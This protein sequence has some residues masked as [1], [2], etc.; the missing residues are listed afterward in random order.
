[1]TMPS[2]AV[3]HGT[4]ASASS[5]ELRKLTKAAGDF[6]SIL[7]DSLWK[8]M[9]ETFSDEEDPDSDP[10]LRS[11][12]DLGIQAVAGAV[13]SAGGFGIKVM[14]IKSLAPQV[15]ASAAHTSAQP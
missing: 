2:T 4:L 13:G 1:M 6:E 3:S 15:Q 11:F 5:P 8:S 9:K 14:I 7:L 10:A 12:D